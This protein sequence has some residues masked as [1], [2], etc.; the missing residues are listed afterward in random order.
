M[1]TGA[2]PQGKGL[3]PVL[4][5]WRAAQPAAVSAKSPRRILADYF[6]TMLILSADF[7]FKPR[8]G[9]DYFLYLKG[10]GWK[11]SLVSPDEWGDRAPGPCLGRCVLKRDMTWELQL[12]TDL[13]SEPGLIEALESFHEG[14]LHLLE[15][16]APLE[17]KLPYFAANLPYYQRLLA[18]GMSSSLAQSLRLS[19]L[20]GR[21]GRQWLRSVPVRAIPSPQAEPA[22]PAGSMRRQPSSL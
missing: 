6:T 22:K 2:N 15:Q 8:P 1:K 18:A 4:D 16:N 9:V 5:A 3:T 11:L 7:A 19:G 20:E 21:S 14:F 10:E 13:D 12:R 17:D